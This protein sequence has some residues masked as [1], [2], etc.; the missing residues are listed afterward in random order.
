[1]DEAFKSREARAH[2]CLH[3][4]Q[5]NPCWQLPHIGMGVVNAGRLRQWERPQEG[6]CVKQYHSGVFVELPM[7]LVVVIWPGLLCLFCVATTA[8]APLSYIRSALASCRRLVSM[9]PLCPDRCVWHVLA[10]TRLESLDRRR[11][12]S[13]RATAEAAVNCLMRRGC[14]LKMQL[15][16]FDGAVWTRPRGLH[17]S[18]QQLFR[19]LEW[20]VFLPSGARAA[21][22]RRLGGVQATSRRRVGDA[23]AGN[24]RSATGVRAAPD[25]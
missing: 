22:E 9:P 23:R 17:G 4:T 12:L 10:D 24:E 16:F 3:R 25:T 5:C 11:R 2:N 8:S 18:M 14:L 15:L 7:F 21:H 20:A 13:L 6:N 1:M 19:E